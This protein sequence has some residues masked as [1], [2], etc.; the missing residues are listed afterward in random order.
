MDIGSPGWGFSFGVAVLRD[1]HIAGTPHDEGTWR[2][3][4]GYGHDW[5]VNPKRRLT[6]VSFTNTAFEG[7]DGTYPTDLRNAIYYALTSEC[8]PKDLRK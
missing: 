5:F 8:G 1:A 3:G 7:S 6:V 2:W 4:G